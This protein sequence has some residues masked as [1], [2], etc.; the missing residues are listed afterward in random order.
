[1]TKKKMNIPLFKVHMP[2]SVMKP[3]KEV[4]FSGLVNEG[5]QVMEFESRLRKLVGNPFTMA[6][7]SCTSSIT[8][9][10]KIAG[11]GPGDEVITSPMTCVATNAPISNLFARPVWCD[12]D[13][14][15]GNIDPVQIEEKITGRT[16]AILFVDWTGIPA[17]LDKIN[18]IGRK[19]GIKVI[20]D[21]AQGIGASYKGRSVGCISDFTCFSFQ[22]IKHINTGDGGALSF[23]D[24]NDF[25]RGKKLKWFGIDREATKD[26]AGNW[27]G[28]RWDCVIPEAGYKFHMNNIDAAIGIEQLKS[29]S[30][31]LKAHR[32]NAEY[33]LKSL[34]GVAGIRMPKIAEGIL[35]A[36]WV[37]MLFAERR[38]DLSRKLAERGVHSSLLHVRN[39]IYGC[40]EGSSALLPGVE[41]F[42]DCELC[43][44]CGWWVGKDEREYI[45][46]VIKEG[47]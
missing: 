36:W 12:I 11:V 5:V 1:M 37:F 39:D 16:K 31:I 45:A 22:A 21:A 3:L 24:E 44:P 7:N 14:N 46:D 20:E 35:P 42:Q 26:S 41:K 17:D 4:L 25:K 29:L 15:T 2:G 34:N 47:W 6:T 8:L 30:G 9:A 10:L 19:R 28:S 27:K 23:S 43:I 13:V 32:R 33:F 18:A 40:F 38:D